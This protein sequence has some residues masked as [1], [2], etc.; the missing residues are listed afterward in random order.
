[1]MT[2]EDIKRLHKVTS[3]YTRVHMF[4]MMKKREP[5]IK[6][7]LSK[8]E[9]EEVETEKYIEREMEELYPS[10]D[11]G[12]FLSSAKVVKEEVKKYNDFL[13]SSFFNEI[14]TDAISH[15]DILIEKE[16]VT[17]TDSTSKKDFSY[18]LGTKK[19]D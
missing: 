5:I 4:K 16:K 10:E 8:I 7:K 15:E 18:K 13:N 6:Q 12:L 1:M 3:K 19:E 9:A 2:E 17:Y 14:V 11:I